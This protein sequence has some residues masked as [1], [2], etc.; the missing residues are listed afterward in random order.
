MSVFATTVQE[1]MRCWNM[2]V[3]YWLARNVYKRLP[4]R[5]AP[6][7]SVS[8][9]SRLIGS[10]CVRVCECVC[11]FAC[12]CDRATVHACVHPCM[13]CHF[14]INVFF[15]QALLTFYYKYVI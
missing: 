12:V 1:G 3:Q 8:L 5:S 11:V 13:L 10:V 15:V 9:P 4:L 7:K 14:I 2:T 6:L